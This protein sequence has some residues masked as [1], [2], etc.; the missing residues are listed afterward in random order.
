MAMAIRERADWNR[1]VP[2]YTMETI[3]RGGSAKHQPRK[4]DD[5]PVHAGLLPG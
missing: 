2:G 4:N 3:Q 5:L 1:Y